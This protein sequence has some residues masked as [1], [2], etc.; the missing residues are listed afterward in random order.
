MEDQLAM[1]FQDI[2]EGAMSMLQ[3]K[4][5]VAATASSST[6]EPKHHRQYI[7]CDCEAPHFRLDTTT[8]TMIVCTPVLLPSEVLYADD[9]FSKYYV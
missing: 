3:A 1:M 5:V 7:N 8:L 2:M 4:E 6:R 9:S